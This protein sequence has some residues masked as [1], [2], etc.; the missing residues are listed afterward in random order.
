[1]FTRVLKVVF[2]VATASVV[3]RLMQ[4]LSEPLYPKPEYYRSH[5]K[6]AFR[7]VSPSGERT[8]GDG[9]AV[10]QR[11]RQG[12]DALVL[13]LS[14]PRHW[15]RRVTLRDTLF[16]EA[17]FRHFKWAGLFISGR[18]KGGNE[19]DPWLDMEAVAAGDFI[20]M[21]DANVSSSDRRIAGMRWASENCLAVRHV[22][23]MDDS[24]LV[25]PFKMAQY[26]KDQLPLRPHSLHCYVRNST[27][28]K[29]TSSCSGN[30]IIMTFDVMRDLLR[31]ATYAPSDHPT[32]GAHMADELALL[33]GVGHANIAPPLHVDP[34]KSDCILLGTCAIA[35]EPNE[36]ADCWDTTC[37][38][39]QW[40]LMLLL[41]WLNAG[42]RLELSTR[43]E[44]G[45]Y[46]QL[47]EE[48]RFA[49]RANNKEGDPEAADL[50]Q[51]VAL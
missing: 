5:W 47:F 6:G 28:S 48:T 26:I 9:W 27:S 10:S 29:P 32:G 13:V 14:G 38:R 18:E 23:A 46:K 35:S 39:G 22:V 34:S 3:V 37:R 24:E 20:F 41:R 49:L 4:L 21:E 25:E 19:L 7:E 8:R 2:A 12:V 44:I 36:Y 51:A 42:E 30:F 11:C 45:S 31:A 50:S 17:A 40:G 43:L 1:M 16:E 15:H 33:R